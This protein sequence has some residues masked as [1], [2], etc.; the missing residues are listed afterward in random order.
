MNKRTFTIVVL[1]TLI[2][3]SCGAKERDIYPSLYISERVRNILV[4]PFDYYCPTERGLSFY[5]PVTNVIPGEIEG[6]AKEILDNLI[7]KE[8][9]S[10]NVK[11]TFYFLTPGDY[12]IL[13]EEALEKNK[14][15]QGLVRFF[16]EKTNTQAI[17]YGKIFRFKDRKGSGWSVSEPASVSFSLTLYNGEDGKILWQ[18]VFDETQKPL[19]ENVL[20]LPLYGKIKW[21]TAEELA[22]RGLK[23]LLKSFPW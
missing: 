16:T 13:L 8:L 21:L 15:H 11:Y 6:K 12:E 10:L 20:N 9:L 7:K 5:C 22:E 4:L 19:S 1:L 2:L 18:R 14:T 3:F 17:L 23:N